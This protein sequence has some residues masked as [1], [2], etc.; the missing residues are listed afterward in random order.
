MRGSWANDADALN[1]S[2]NRNVLAM[3][4][5]ATPPASTAIETNSLG[6]NHMIAIT[7]R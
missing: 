2:V 4:P 3:G 1:A 7:S 6:L 5:V